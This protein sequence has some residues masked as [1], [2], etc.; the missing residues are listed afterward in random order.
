MIGWNSS[1]RTSADNWVSVLKIR[2]FGQ[3]P[4]EFSRQGYYP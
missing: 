3:C 2:A 4:D 1:T